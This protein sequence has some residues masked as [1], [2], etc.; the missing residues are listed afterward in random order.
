MPAWAQMQEFNF[1][2]ANLFAGPQ[3]VSFGSNE[4]VFSHNVQSQLD[5]HQMSSMLD[6]AQV[7]AQMSNNYYSEDRFGDPQP[8]HFSQIGTD[9]PA[10]ASRNLQMQEALAVSEELRIARR[11]RRA[12]VTK[13]KFKGQGKGTEDNPPDYT[14]LDA[15]CSLCLNDF[16]RGDR[17]LRLRCGHVFH[18][19]CFYGNE[20]NTESPVRS[21]PNCRGH[22]TVVA[23]FLY[24]MENEQ[25]QENEENQGENSFQMNTPRSQSEG[26]A[27]AQGTPERPDHLP[28]V[29]LPWWVFLE[30]TKLPDG[31]LSI[32]VDPG[33]FTNLGGKAWARLQARIA[34]AH[35]LKPEQVKMKEPISVA[36]VGNG[37]QACSWKGKFPIAVNTENGTQVHSFETPI[38]EGS[39]ENLPALLGLKSMAAKGAI[40]EMQEGQEYLTFPGPGGYKI[41]FAPGATRIKLE[42]A[43]SG[44]LV[45]PCDGFDK[46]D[47]KKSGGVPDEKFCFPMGKIPTSNS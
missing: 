27:S 23:R 6:F 37:T 15:T 42:K 16:N 29:V 31:R 38:V 13:G 41:E 3:P 30:T 12:I 20:E 25:E 17:V 40:L 34:M 24:V 28:S 7:Q 10:S 47:S 39:G 35:G 26:F 43:P 46:V 2:N 18:I 44:H 22:P 9:M 33:A 21:C 36:G 19:N 45:I 1:T 8:R 14:G 5:R 32:I 11:A 4:S